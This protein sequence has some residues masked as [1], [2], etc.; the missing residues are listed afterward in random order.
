MD[1][2]SKTEGKGSQKT[3]KQMRQM[4]KMAKKQ[5]T[6]KQAKAPKQAPKQ[7]PESFIQRTLVLV[8]PDGVQRALAGRIIQRFEDAGL[9]IVAMKMKW[10]DRDF[11]KKHY[12]AHLGKPMYLRLEN[13]I[14][15]GPVIAMAIEG[16]SA[17]ETVRK[18]VGST[19]PKS[20]L[21]GT[22]RGD[23]AQHSYQYTDQKGIAI[24]NLIHAS[25]NEEEADYEIKLW[26]N[27]EEIHSYRTV[28]EIHVF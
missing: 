12:F 8:K 25:G 13:F 14:V 7:N 28:H 16:V 22:I 1:S 19:E 3:M 5:S 9:K 17:I 24:K 2:N 20:A 10:I 21:P 6:Q 15:S 11:A 26:F 23:F 27:P 4:I 18:L